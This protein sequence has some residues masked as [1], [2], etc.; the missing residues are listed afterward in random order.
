MTSE[1]D[2]QLDAALAIARRALGD[3]LVAACLYGSA[4]HGGL[5]RWSDLDLLILTRD[6]PPPSALHASIACRIASVHSVVPS[7]TAP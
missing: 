1:Q 5:Q 2:A 7:P 4:T 6:R 3:E